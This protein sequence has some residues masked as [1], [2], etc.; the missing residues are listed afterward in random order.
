MPLHTRCASLPIQNQGFRTTFRF[1]SRESS[2]RITFA[3]ACLN[4]GIVWAYRCQ[5]V[6]GFATLVRHFLCATLFGGRAQGAL[7]ARRFPS[8]PVHY[9]RTAATQSFSSDSGQLPEQAGVVIKKITLP[10]FLCPAKCCSVRVTVA[11]PC[12]GALDHSLYDHKPARPLRT[13]LLANHEK[14]TVYSIC[15]QA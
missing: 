1:L 6:I 11:G 15:A 9:L 3:C 14:T 5:T 8:S 2:E 13:T 4:R 12:P 10:P 7:A